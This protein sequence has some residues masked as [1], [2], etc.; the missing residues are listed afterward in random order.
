M[1]DNLSQHIKALNDSV[2]VINNTIAIDIPESGM[3]TYKNK[4]DLERNIEHIEI[5]LQKDY[6]QQSNEDLSIYN[7]AVTDGS[8]FLS[9]N[10]NTHGVYRNSDSHV[11]R[12]EGKFS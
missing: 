7:N 10:S 5:M 6:I 2:D 4:R 8:N 3:Y 12:S 9:N 1:S 11:G